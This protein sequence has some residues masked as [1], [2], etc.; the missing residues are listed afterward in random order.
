MLSYTS[1]A[2]VFSS[3]VHVFESCN[4]VLFLIWKLGLNHSFSFCSYGF[5]CPWQQEVNYCKFSPLIILF[6]L[7]FFLFLIIFPFER[8]FR[9]S[10]IYW[11]ALKRFVHQILLWF[12]TFWCFMLLLKC[13]YLLFFPFFNWW[14]QY[15]QPYFYCQLCF[16]SFRLPINIHGANHSLSQVLTWSTLGLPRRF[17]PLGFC[18]APNGIKVFSVFFCSIFLSLS[19]MQV[20]FDEDVHHAKVFPRLRDVHITFG[21]FFQCFTQKH[22]YL[23][24]S[25][26]PTFGLL[27]S[28]CDFWFNHYGGF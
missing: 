19:F 6:I 23:L 27:T 16:W 20:A 8:I 17:S 24:F 18:Y 11:C 14:H 2:I 22:S 28:T 13:F 5:L 15:F 3:Y 4:F 9:P 26:P 21:I 12:C 25:F 1:H 10:F 7:N